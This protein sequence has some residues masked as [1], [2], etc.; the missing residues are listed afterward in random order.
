MLQTVIASTQDVAIPA[1]RVARS[2][3]AIAA[4]S[5]RSR[6]SSSRMRSKPVVLV[7]NHG[8]LIPFTFTFW[9]LASTAPY[10]AMG[11]TTASTFDL[12]LSEIFLSLC[13]PVSERHISHAALT[14]AM[15]VEPR[16]PTKSVLGSSMSSTWNVVNSLTSYGSFNDGAEADR[17]KCSF[18][19]SVYVRGRCYVLTLHNVVCLE[20]RLRRRSLQVSRNSVKDDDGEEW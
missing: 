15:S 19:A 11:R 20:Q 12:K 7:I 14:H 17:A 3:S 10:T 8:D 16:Y 2:L 18:H 5:N 9:L 13:T 4:M 6:M 1:R